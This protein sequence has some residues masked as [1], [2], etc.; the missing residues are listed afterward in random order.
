MRGPRRW[1]AASHQSRQR[2]EELGKHGA[3]SERGVKVAHF[4]EGMG[5]CVAASA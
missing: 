3:L 1:R 5:F 4:A 2:R